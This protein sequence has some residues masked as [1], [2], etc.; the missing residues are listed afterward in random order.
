M[1]LTLWVEETG[2]QRRVRFRLTWIP[3]AG[4]RRWAEVGET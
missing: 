2:E 4:N 1:A 3:L